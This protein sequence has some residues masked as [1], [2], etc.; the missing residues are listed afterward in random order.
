MAEILEYIERAN[1]KLSDS[2]R[3]ASTEK[4]LQKRVDDLRRKV[5]ESVKIFSRHGLVET[6]STK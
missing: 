6:E 3:K 1:K 5:N 2:D 4:E